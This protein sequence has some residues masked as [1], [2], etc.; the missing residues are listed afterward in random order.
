MNLNILLSNE[1][2]LEAFVSYGKVIANKDGIIQIVGLEHLVVG[3]VSTIG[4]NEKI[5]YE[6]F[7]Y[8]EAKAPGII[9]RKPVRE[10]MQTG[11][12]C[13]DSAISI[14]RG[15]RELITVERQAEKTIA[16]GVIAASVRD[17]VL[18][19]VIAMLI[20]KWFA[21]LLLATSYFIYHTAPI[22]ISSGNQIDKPITMQKN[23]KR[24]NS[25][26][27]KNLTLITPRKNTLVRAF[28]NYS[29]LKSFQEWL[30][31]QKL[32]EFDYPLQEQKLEEWIRGD[33][34]IDAT[35]ITGWLHSMLIA[36][37]G[38]I[39]HLERIALHPG[40]PFDRNDDACVKDMVERIYKLCY[41]PLLREQIDDWF[42]YRLLLRK[43]RHVPQSVLEPSEESLI[44]RLQYIHWV[45]ELM[46]NEIANPLLS[47]ELRNRLFDEMER[48]QSESP[49]FPDYIGD[50]GYP[51]HPHDINIRSYKDE[52]ESERRETIAFWEN[53]I[54]I[55][56][57]KN[58]RAAAKAAARLLRR[59]QVA[60]SADHIARRKRK[61]FRFPRGERRRQSWLKRFNR[62][63]ILRW[64]KSTRLGRWL[65]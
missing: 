57:A 56:E 36:D 22:I 33:L 16:I 31:E 61:L 9:V 37:E 60:A 7:N 34:K 30:Q 15:Q 40:Y 51:H 43:G 29:F 58:A 26:F 5:V 54:K 63:S 12:L 44:Y 62:N 42:D 35:D 28:S 23:T 10:A 59:K 4:C 6:E 38:C 14:V 48:I 47:E 49:G 32:E 52:S 41:R 27:R 21:V 11:I 1:V 39:F 13:I 19:E 65:S 25:V 55:E 2:K 64:W 3:E 18:D 45:I 24:I 20:V 50:D 46:H 8:V 53:Q 17:N